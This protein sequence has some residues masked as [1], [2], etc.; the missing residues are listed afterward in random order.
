MNAGA[1]MEQCREAH[2]GRVMRCI[3]DRPP[4][5]GELFRA[6]VERYP[7][8]CALAHGAVRF[9][10]SE[11][12]RNVARIAANL[13][14]L[15][16]CAGDRIATFLDNGPEQIEVLL[17]AAIMG[18][19]LVPIGPRAR[20]PEIEYIL[21]N[22]S[23]R[24]LVHD[25]A[26]ADQAPSPAGALEFRY[27]VNGTC[28]GSRNFEE[29]YQPVAQRIFAPVCEDDVAW[30]V[31]TSGT[32]GKPKGAM[33]SHCGVV[34]STLNYRDHLALGCDERIMLA[35][36]LSHITGL[37]A[38]L[39]PS[40]LV[41]ATLF[42]SGPFK[43]KRFLEL[44]AQA[45]M[46]YTLMVP[47]MYNLI[48]LERDLETHDLSSWRVGGFGGAPMPEATIAAISRLWPQLTLQNVYGATETTGPATILPP[49]EIRRHR[50]SVG[51][52]VACSDL[53]VMNEEGR[54]VLPGTP[55]E[56]WI[57]GPQTAMGYWG[58]PDGTRGAFV[59]GFWRSGDVASIDAQGFVYILD[60][61]K[62]MINRGGFKIYS[63]EVEGVLMEHP[64]VIEAALVGRS[65]PVLGERAH[66]FIFTRAPV[67][68]DLIRV[69]LKERLSDYKVPD[70]FTLMSEPLPRNA[71]GKVMKAD[72]RIDL[73]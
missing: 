14:A 34:H 67:D 50:L 58:N 9:T 66:A 49:G 6:S 24:V 32:T 47:A 11:L 72:L 70:F 30:L 29:L 10:Y 20:L 33:L 62:D 60:R 5:I 13:A 65:C 41:G 17:A 63:P 16:L 39:L 8:R 23:A 51:K 31:Y 44:A 1:A 71:N 64:A 21:Q 3:S 57:A 25:A 68:L 28:A 7:N 54:E 61:K 42:I 59:G 2:H 4:N 37:G 22:C 46:T 26:L 48:A 73:P 18:A 40:L 52:A 35:V 36:P 69:F 12:D 38:V 27:S 19:I 56:L 53:V 43:A 15:G 45:R 55:G